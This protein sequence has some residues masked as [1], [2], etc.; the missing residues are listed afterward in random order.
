VDAR[1]EHGINGDAMA[2]AVGISR[3]RLRDIEN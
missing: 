2:Q 1:K 3:G